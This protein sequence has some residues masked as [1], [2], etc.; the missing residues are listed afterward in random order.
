ML[1]CMTK[2]SHISHG[3][4]ISPG[5]ASVISPASS[6]SENVVMT[7]PIIAPEDAALVSEVDALVPE[8]LLQSLSGSFRERTVHCIMDL[9]Q[10]Y[11]D[12]P[13]WMH[14]FA[15]VQ[16]RSLSEDPTRRN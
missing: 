14:D 16:R 8:Q 6:G 15:R 9:S 2:D 1:S 10:T 11:P 13:A 4:L 3:E 5:A 12:R 7:R